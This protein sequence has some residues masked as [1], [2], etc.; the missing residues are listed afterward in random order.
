MPNLSPNNQPTSDSG[1]RVVIFLRKQ[2]T[3]LYGADRWFSDSW[4]NDSWVK[5][6]EDILLYI[7][8]REC[9]RVTGEETNLTHA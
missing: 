3:L 6:Y 1:S 4:S 9:G 7:I 2:T 8:Y 5:M